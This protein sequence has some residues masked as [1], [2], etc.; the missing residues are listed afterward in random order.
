MEVELTGFKSAI[1][2]GILLNVADVHSE[3]VQLEAG[4]LTENVTV[5]VHQLSIQ[6]VG[7]EVA[8]L[9]TGEQVRELPLNGRNFLQLGTLM[10]GVSQ[11]DTFNTKDRGLMSGIELSVSGSGLGGNMANRN[12][13]GTN[14]FTGCIIALNPDAGKMAWYFQPMPHDTHDWD[15]TETA[16]L[17]D[18]PID[19]RPRKLLAQASRNGVFFVLDRVT[20]KALTSTEFVKTSWMLGFDEQGQP[21]PNPAKM[22]Q[23]SGALV[24]PDSG[25]AANWPAPS[26]SPKTGLFY[27]NASRSFSM[28]YIYD[29]GS[30]PQGWGGTDRGG[31]SEAMTEAIDYTTG[32]VRWIHRWE[33]GARAGIVSTA[34][35]LVFTGGSSNDLVAL[36]AT[37]GDALWHARLNAPIS[38]GP[39]TYDLDGRQYLVIA[40]AES[41]WAFVLNDR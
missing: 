20:G 36:D 31:W 15:A 10:P 18:A 39:I 23:E 7:G 2:K 21:I 11:G 19:G 38:N 37:T 17:I 9:V 35:N 22:P 24:S 30:N 14:L 26:V 13:G 27:V 12:R 34:G 28:F 32:K 5:E 3:D 8:G 40:A 41:I 6:T 29:P 33:G 1:R 4:A 16:V 25:G